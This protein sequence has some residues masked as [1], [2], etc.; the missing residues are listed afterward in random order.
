LLTATLRARLFISGLLYTHTFEFFSCLVSFA[1]F[2]TA[3]NSP[4][5]LLRFVHAVAPP[6]SVFTCVRFL[7]APFL[8]LRPPVY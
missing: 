6:I 7:T 8:A 5:F 4:D 2:F 3:K 1:G